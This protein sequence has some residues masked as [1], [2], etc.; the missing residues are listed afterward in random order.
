[1]E[2][3]FNHLKEKA[4]DNSGEQVSR[5]ITWSTNSIST[6]KHKNKN[7]NVLTAQI[8]VYLNIYIKD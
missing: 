1:M 5:K 3:T 7:R 2:R 4:L 8:S 6:F